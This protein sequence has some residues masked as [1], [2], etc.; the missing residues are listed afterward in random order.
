MES[1]NLNWE[2][3]NILWGLTD[4]NT[5]E[6]VLKKA[7]EIVHRVRF[8]PVATVNNGQPENRIIDFNLLPDGNLY[9]MT[10][11]G[12]PFYK[13]LCERPEIVLNTSVDML[14][15]LKILPMQAPIWQSLH[16]SL[17]H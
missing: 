3:E 17:L 2:P 4:E 7:F 11:K 10:S 14:Y 1:R 9:F 6:E 12:K 8:M 5:D 16:L 15:A 13:Q